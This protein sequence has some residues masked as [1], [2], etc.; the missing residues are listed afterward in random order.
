MS[1]TKWYLFRIEKREP[2]IISKAFSTKSEAEKARSKSP[3]RERKA[4]GI[5]HVKSDR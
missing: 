4:T 2:Q 5:G 3:E 1:K